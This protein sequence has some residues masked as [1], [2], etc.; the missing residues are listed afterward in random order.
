MKLLALYQRF[1]PRGMNL[2][3]G[4]RNDALKFK[5]LGEHAENHKI[6]LQ[7]DIGY[8]ED[9]IKEDYDVVFFS[10]HG[11]V[12]NGNT[13]LCLPRSGSRRYSHYLTE[14]DYVDTTEISRNSLLLLDCCFAE[15]FKSTVNLRKSL[16]GYRI[17]DAKI[18]SFGQGSGKIIT[19]YGHDAIYASQ[20]HEASYDINIGDTYGGAFTWSLLNTIATEDLKSTTQE[21]FEEVMQILCYGLGA[22]QHPKIK[23]SSDKWNLFLELAELVQK[24]IK[25][26]RQI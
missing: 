8:I 9:H 14:K 22:H 12:D 10:G 4:P 5:I 24:L 1:Y 7:V 16:I 2:L 21:R 23:M 11:A 6:D 18:K 17:V 26:I 20:A 13:L 25:V 15:G 3:K 19:D